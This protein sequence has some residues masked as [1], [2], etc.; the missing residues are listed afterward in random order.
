MRA[1]VKV[2]IVALA[3]AS[4]GLAGLVGAEVVQKG[5][6]RVSVGAE[7]HPKRLPRT[8]FA[9]I[10]VSISSGL[11]ATDG[12]V[13]PPLK[14]LQIDLNRHGR[15]DATGLPE[16]QA[17]QIQ[18]ASTSRALEVCGQAL[19][20][21][22]SFSVDV[23]LGAQEPY[24]ARGRLLLFNARYKGRPALLGQI[25]S[26]HPFANSFVIVFTI[27]RRRNG[28]Y[29][30]TLAATIP[31]ALRAWGNLTSISMRLRRTYTYRGRRRSYLSAGC[32][33]PKGF[34]RVPF[35]LARARFAFSAGQRITSTVSGECAVRR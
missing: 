32:P 24:P 8:G 12:G 3:L 15:L 4:L 25:Y 14:T 34:H 6:V 27:D 19:V 29:G 9:P 22:G 21:R 13:P 28:P 5:K 2:G 10:S 30:T 26:A 16:C 11:A 31:T 33:A 23:V 18:P 17:S 1:Q 35:P 20:G 7:L